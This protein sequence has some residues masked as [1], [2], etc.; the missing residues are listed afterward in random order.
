MKRRRFIAIGVGALITGVSIAAVQYWRIM[1]RAVIRFNI[2]APP[3][4]LLR[5][6]NLIQCTNPN[7]PDYWGTP[8][9]AAL[10]DWPGTFYVENRA[11]QEIKKSV[12][13]M[14]HDVH[15]MRLYNPE[16][17]YALLFQSYGT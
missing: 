8:A 14:L 3:A 9:P 10:R 4:N 15:S 17:P 7:M 12:W 16:T 13:A 1:R 5:N 6:A 11:P 2:F